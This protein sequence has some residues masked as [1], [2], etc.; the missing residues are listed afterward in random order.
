MG[1]GVN[2]VS[3]IYI[4]VDTANLRDKYKK[5][6]FEK[7]KKKIKKHHSMSLILNV[8]DFMIKGEDES[9]DDGEDSDDERATKKSKPTPV[10]D[11]K[12]LH[13]VVSSTTH[14]NYKSS[15]RTGEKTSFSMN[16]VYLLLKSLL[17]DDW[18]N[19]MRDI[20]MKTV[21]FAYH[22]LAFG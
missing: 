20:E 8:D 7:L 22:E 21:T 3:C 10:S 9:Y 6:S 16:N 12:E 17:G 13:I 19:I 1:Y 5:L 18:N 14:Y 15:E 2:G 4:T 11:M